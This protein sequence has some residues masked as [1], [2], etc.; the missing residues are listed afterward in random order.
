[1]RNGAMRAGQRP[2]KVELHLRCPSAFLTIQDLRR[3]RQRHQQ[4]QASDATAKKVKRFIV[5]TLP[6]T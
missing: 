5:L 4:R 6:L 2:E 3:A 1:M